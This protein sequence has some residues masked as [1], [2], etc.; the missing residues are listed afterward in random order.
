[1]YKHDHDPTFGIKSDTL[2]ARYKIIKPGRNIV[3]SLWYENGAGFS[4]EVRDPTFDKRVMKFC[5]SIP[6]D[7]Y[8]RE[9]TDRF[10]I[11]RAMHGILPSK[12]RL[13]T[14]RGRQAAD[15]GE[16][17]CKSF[18]EIKSAIEIVEKSE[19]GNEFLDIKKMRRIFLEQQQNP[20]R[21]NIKTAQTILL[22]ELMVGLFLLRFEK[23]KI[24]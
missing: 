4:M 5:M 20:G 12:V 16:R 11:R 22:R 13:N 21:E 1:M 7:Q 3:G 15:K 9:G 2:Q 17:L 18:D 8:V 19:L 10:L 14:L 6:D 24:I 23:N